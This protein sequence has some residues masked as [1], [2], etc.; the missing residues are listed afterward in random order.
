MR[1]LYLHVCE[2]YLLG[3]LVLLSL[4]ENIGRGIFNSRVFTPR[5]SKKLLLQM[6]FFRKG[7]G[8]HV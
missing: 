8:V 7:L 2:L 4:L 5:F 6:G 3:H 1:G